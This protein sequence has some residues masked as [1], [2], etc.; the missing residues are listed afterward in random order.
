MSVHLSECVLVTSTFLLCILQ[1]YSSLWLKSETLVTACSL[2]AHIE[3]LAVS[4]YWSLFADSCKRSTTPLLCAAVFVSRE[5]RGE[6]R[7]GRA[8]LFRALGGHWGVAM[9]GNDWGHALNWASFVEALWIKLLLEKSA[10]GQHSQSSL[11]NQDVWV[12]DEPFCFMITV[13]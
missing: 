5:R 12:T 6:G 9:G 7:G 13:V 8:V 1:M 10:W 3:Y 11:L 4:V 2:S